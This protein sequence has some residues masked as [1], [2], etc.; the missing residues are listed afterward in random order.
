MVVG[1]GTVSGGVRAVSRIS[2]HRTVGWEGEK[3][4]VTAHVVYNRRSED[5]ERARGRADSNASIKS[6][7]TVHSAWKNG[8][9]VNRRQALMSIMYL[10]DIPTQIQMLSSFGS[11]RL[12]NPTRPRR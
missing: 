11:T 9:P 4:K 2:A 6:Q 3:C 12:G 7:P 1:R 5:Q 8:L 10:E